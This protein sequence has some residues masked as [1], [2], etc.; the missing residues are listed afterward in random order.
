MKIICAVKY[1]P[2]VDKFQFDFE[3]NVVIRHNIRMILNPDD[4]KAVGL[5]LEMKKRDSSVSVEVLCMGPK[6]VLPMVKDL[7]RMGVDKVTLLSDTRFVGS[8]SY[9]TSKILGTYLENQKADLIIT[10]NHS[11]DGDTSHVPSQLADHLKL[12]HMYNIVQFYMDTMKNRQVEFTVE[13]EMKRIRFSMKLPGILSLSKDAAYRLPYIGYEEMN[14]ET[15]DRITILNAE[16]LGF[17]AHEVGI[18]GSKTKVKRT[19]VKE[20][21]KRDQ[22][23]ISTDADGIEKIYQF[24]QKNG[25]VGGKVRDE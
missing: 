8:D 2:D 10:G 24:L 6:S 1:V 21:R 20:Y 22:E 3:K 7:V 13:N 23:T 19:F 5:A 9:I 15:G 14:R 25:Y 12:P 17:D 4:G 11:M 18:K 16:D